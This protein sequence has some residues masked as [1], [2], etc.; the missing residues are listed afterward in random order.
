V[1]GPTA[2][3]VRKL[4]LK[5][6]WPAMKIA[7][8][9]VGV[10]ELARIGW[11]WLLRTTGTHPDR[12]SA[13]RRAEQVDGLIGTALL[14]D[15]AHWVVF[16]NDEPVIAYPRFDGD[17]AA[18][19]R[20]YRRDQLRSPD[21]L[22]SRRAQAW[23]KARVSKV[24]KRERPATNDSGLSGGS[25]ADEFRQILDDLQPLLA[26]LTESPK[27]K[28]ADHPSI[29]RAPG[30]YLFSEGPNPIYVGQSRNLDQSLGQY[31][32]ASSDENS[33]PLAFNLAL[34]EAGA[35]GHDIT[36]ARGE[37]A[38]RP[39]FD[40]LFADARRRVAEM[41]VQVVEVGDSVTRTIFEVYA[42]RILG[43]D[44]FNSWDAH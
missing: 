3:I 11:R 28:L 42:A 38:A 16:K 25:G 23:F 31:T 13:I 15:G 36:G 35:Q 33:T 34:R 19:L 22:P 7:A 32:A 24:V 40:V 39:E 29:P 2:W 8:S 6:G 5:Y 10:D 12:R 17:L 30:I 41:H 37:I 4:F 27:F 9:V 26:R 21:A 18:G 44:E 20:D 43:T 14:D 1:P